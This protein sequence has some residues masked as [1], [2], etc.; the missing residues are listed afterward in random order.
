[1]TDEHNFTGENN[2]NRTQ[3]QH[4]SD[5]HERKTGF[6]VILTTVTMV[7]EIIFGYLTNSMALLADG[8]H[9]SSHAF[10]LGLSWLAYI[11]AR[12]YA[13]TDKISFKKEKLLALSGFTSAIVL[14]IVAIYMGI[15]SSDRLLNPVKIMFTEAI[16]VAVIGL[17]VNVIS[18]FALHHK[19]EHSDHNIR[20]A[21]LHVLADGLTSVTAIIALTIG[22]LYNLYWLDA[23]SGI[24]SSLVITKWAIELIRDSGQELIEYKR[25]E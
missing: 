16:F 21:Y 1:M 4:I 25:I 20:S 24:I 3:H 12:K 2:K 11:F 15:Q 9:M 6:V 23:L 17:I 8:Y 19:K 7:V 14:Q 18:A 13:Q 10:A 22:L 5:N